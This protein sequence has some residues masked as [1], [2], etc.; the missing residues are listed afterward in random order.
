MDSPK[1]QARYQ[2]SKVANIFELIDSD[3]HKDLAEIKNQTDIKYLVQD[4]EEWLKRRSEPGV[5][6]GVSTGYR[7]IDGLLGSFEGGELLTIGGD[8]GHG[9]SLLA[10]NIA[11]N[12]YSERQEPVMVVSMELT[13]DQTRERFYELSGEEH[14]YAGILI[15]CS[16]ELRYKD[17]D[18][19]MQKAK[20]EKACL[21]VIDHL[22]FFDASIGDNP[23]NAITRV[24]KHFKECARNLDMPVILLSHVTPS[25]NVDGSIKKPELHD[26]RSSR[27]IEQLSDMVGFVFRD[28]GSNR[29]EFYLRKNRSRPLFTHSVNLIQEGW[30][31]IEE[32]KWLPGF[33]S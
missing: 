9:K 10:F 33:R 13:E 23:S 8:T 1:N 2:R 30:K 20:E 4:Q 14:D 11:Q 7:S 12:V 19:I 26:L 17:I 3:V 24:V 25:K 16:S 27:S 21:V 32:D 22:H 5:Y 15:Q 6:A 28:K 18:I 31:L 29:V